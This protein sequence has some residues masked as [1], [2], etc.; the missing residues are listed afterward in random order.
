MH[1]IGKWFFLFKF[2]QIPLSV[3]VHLLLLVI[4]VVNYQVVAAFMMMETLRKSGFS[5]LSVSIPSLR[6]FLQILGIAAP[7]FMTMTSK[8]WVEIIVFTYKI[9]HYSW[10][11]YFQVAFYSLLTYSATSMGTITIAAHQVFL[12]DCFFLSR[13]HCFVYLNIL[14]I[15][16]PNFNVF[17]AGYD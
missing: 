3:F 15:S 7:V 10:V 6:D 13:F 14:Y 11:S 1:L 16:L 5:A 4:I 17:N 9:W 8:V 2:L 12:L